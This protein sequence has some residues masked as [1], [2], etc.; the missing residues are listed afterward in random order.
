M[1]VLDAFSSDAIPTHLLTREGVR[2]LRAAP[3]AE[4]LRG[5]PHLEP[6]L[7]SQTGVDRGGSR[8]RQAWSRRTCHAK[9]PSEANPPPSGY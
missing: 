2:D 1:L 8:V 9:S 4:G 7:R 3:R 5:G 6:A